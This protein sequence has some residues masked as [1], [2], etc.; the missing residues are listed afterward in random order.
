[1][2]TNNSFHQNFNII[3]NWKCSLNILTSKQLYPLL[4]LSVNRRQCLSL[5]WQKLLQ[6]TTG[7]I[8]KQTWY[9]EQNAYLNL[10]GR[11]WIELGYQKEKNIYIHLSSNTKALAVA[12]FS[13]CADFAQYDCI[14]RPSWCSAK[15]K[16]KI[17]PLWYYSTK[18][19]VNCFVRD[20]ITSQGWKIYYQCWVKKRG[21]WGIS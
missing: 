11:E 13:S 20:G 18:L 12:T 8:E 6:D 14:M 4:S 10:S 1:M 7:V 17:R 5:Y 3:I 21:R 15:P 19:D 9:R 16:Y 2:Y